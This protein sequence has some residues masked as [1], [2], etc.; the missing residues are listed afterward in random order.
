MET[1]TDQEIFIQQSQPQVIQN[2]S[3]IPPQPTPPF[4]AQEVRL[5]KLK[6]LL[7][8]LSYH[9]DEMTYPLKKINGDESDVKKH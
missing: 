2:L 3:D 5:N 6:Q 8:S 7:V 1:N 4:F 9:K